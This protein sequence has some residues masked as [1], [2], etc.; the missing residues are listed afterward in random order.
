MAV[1][2]TV[3]EYAKKKRGK[4]RDSSLLHTLYK[5]LLKTDHGPKCKTIKLTEF[6]KGNK[7]ETHCELGLGKKFLNIK[8]IFHEIK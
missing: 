6:I 2:Q 8:S 7:G 3:H 1:E 4:K 5:T